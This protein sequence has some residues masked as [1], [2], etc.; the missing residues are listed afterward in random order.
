MDKFK[1]NPYNSNNNFIQENDIINIMRS[2]NINDFKL[3]D[4]FLYQRCFIHKSYCKLKDYEEYKN[5][6]N[7]LELQDVS[8]E[9]IEFLG[10]AILEKSVCSYLYHRFFLIH[11]K[12]EGFL[13]K[14]KIRIVCGENLSELSKKIGFQKFL[15]ISDHIDRNCDGRNNVNI[16]EDVFESFIG[17]LYLDQGDKF[18]DNFIISVIEKYIDFTDI[19]LNDNNYKDKII[20]YIQQNYNNYPKYVHIKNED[21]N[22]Y[23]CQL[24]LDDKLICESEGKSKKKS[25]QNVSKKCLIQFNVL[26]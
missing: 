22:N 7:D 8:Y 26:T 16:L 11:N 24:Y 5:I 20:R 23:I 10:D 1:A 15:I 6:N 3:N 17:A 19:L 9:T 13:T 12:D 2:L 25:E 4:I 18:V 14:L 21:T